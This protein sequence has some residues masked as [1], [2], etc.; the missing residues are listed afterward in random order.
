[1]L[2][3]WNL[4]LKID[5]KLSELPLY[6][7]I[8]QTLIE[9]IISGTLKKGDALPGTRKLSILFDVN[10]NTV[11]EAYNLLEEKGWVVSK[12]R[13]GTFISAS[14]PIKG[15]NSL[16]IS[17]DKINPGKKKIGINKIVFDQG[18]PDPSYSP[19]MDLLREYRVTIKKILRQTITLY[20]DPLGYKKLRIVLSQMLNQQRRIS[21][22]ENSICIT[23]GSQM[24]LF[25]VSQCLL[26]HND[27][28][29]VE[30]PGYRL[31]WEAF[32]YS[33]ATVLFAGVD[34]DGILISD[35]E[36]Y[37][38]MGK[39]IKAVYVSPNSQ[40]PTTAIL[41]EER[42][43]KLIDLSNRHGFYIIEDDYCID[44]NFSDKRLFPL[45]SDGNVKNYIYIGTFSRSVSPLM[46][47]GY[48]VSTHSFIKKIAALRGIIDISGDAVMERAFYSIIQD[49]IYIKHLKKIVIF[50][51]NKRNFMEF[52]LNKYLKNKIVYIK[53]ELGLGY[54]IV[55]NRFE[56]NN[57]IKKEL[58]REG[59]R[60]LISDDYYQTEKKGFFLSFGSLSEK[61]LEQGIQII[62]R[63]L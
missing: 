7:Q 41:S 16:I 47:M 43:R 10:R 34:T 46:K 49:R 45:C 11:V 31:A 35:I 28:V 61:K 44:L 29:I 13:K 58:F 20:N 23:R 53:P 27:C 25:L 36:A 62:S 63:Y 19:I 15:L 24:A 12:L 38:E 51:D 6:K 50:Y 40:F 2:R 1:M 55:P 48:L 3:P 17:T 52:L 14:I 59:I 22:D 37:L 54:W 26:N 8:S 5:K 60:A 39:N 57:N 42:R 9:A 33:G 4:D 56:Y 18:L 21:S 32:K 30:N